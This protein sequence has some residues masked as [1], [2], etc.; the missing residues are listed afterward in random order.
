MAITLKRTSDNLVFDLPDN[1]IWADEFGWNKSIFTK[2]YTFHG[3]LIIE[4]SERQNGRP[5]TL[6][7]GLEWAWMRR[8]QLE[9]L[10]IALTEV[11]EP[12]ALTLHD[13]RVFS[14]VPN[15]ETDG[16][17]VSTEQL[18]TVKGSGDA[19]PTSNSYYVIKELKFITV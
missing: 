14:V 19:D 5:I 8:G 11:T 6:V 10:Q 18:P 12:F 15:N 9:Q 1:L 7:G 13:G 4:A 3:Q 17:A 2:A 16:G